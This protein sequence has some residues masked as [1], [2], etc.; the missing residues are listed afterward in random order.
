MSVSS[1]TPSNRVGM[2]LVCTFSYAGTCPQACFRNLPQNFTQA[3]WAVLCAQ[4]EV[5]SES[6]DA[7][8]TLLNAISEALLSELRVL[9]LQSFFKTPGKAQPERAASEPAESPQTVQKPRQ[10]YLDLFSP[11]PEHARYA[12][13]HQDC[14]LGRPQLAT[15]LRSAV[16]LLD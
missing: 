7:A 2:C 13:L 4:G 5:S 6:I 11:A 12:C 9:Y 14:Y 15:M 1:H 3:Y 8:S 16:C 10:P